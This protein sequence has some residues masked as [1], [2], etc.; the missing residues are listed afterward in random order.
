LK[1][2]VAKWDTPKK[3]FFL[4]EHFISNLHVDISFSEGVLSSFKFFSFPRLTS[5]K[6][7]FSSDATA[8]LLPY[9]IKNNDT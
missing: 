1:I 2:K 5:N 9:Q 7:S 8:T 3:Y 6:I 4:K